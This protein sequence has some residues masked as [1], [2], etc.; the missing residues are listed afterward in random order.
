MRRA[1]FLDRDGVLNRA[2]VR[3]GRPYPPKRLE[4]FELY[5]DVLA[6]CAKL[7]AAGFL[8][9]VVTNQPDVARGAQKREVVDGMHEKLLTDLPQIA[10]IEV[11]WHAGSDWGDPCHCRKP[12]PGMVLHAAQTL[13]I[14]V[15]ESFFIGDR[16]RDMDCGYAAGCRTVFIDRGYSGTL[17]HPPDWTVKSF[18]QAVEVILRASQ[19]T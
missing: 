19:V 10:Q 4:E 5:E 3:D 8:Q 14:D 2:V 1:V 6:G 7:H 17:R 13:D 18:G 9:I 11:C 12:L 15:R 16:W